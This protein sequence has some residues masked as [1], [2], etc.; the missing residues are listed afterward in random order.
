M[1][2]LASPAQLRASFLRW[3][4]V[5]V[6]VVE[7]LG[8]LS[9]RLGDDATSPWFSSLVKPAIF[10][11]PAVFGIV[12]SVLFALIALA[13]VLLITARGARGRGA[14][15]AAWI[16]TFVLIL[17]WSPVFFAGHRITAGLY[18]LFA[19]DVAA[20]A[21][22]ILAYRVRPLAG[23]LMAP[24]LAWVLFATVLNW[25]FLL[26]NPAA[27]GGAASTVSVDLQ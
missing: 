2:E 24:F 13:L 15:I 10:P 19:I 14:A 16:V 21:A 4:V 17:G 23:A 25:Q 22:T 3:A 12:W 1:S 11:P 6:P 20:L 7:L 18:L 26:A 5:L 27:D 9:G 8:F